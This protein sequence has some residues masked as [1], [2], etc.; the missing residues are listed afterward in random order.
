MSTIKDPAKASRRVDTRRLQ[1]QIS[2]L[3]KRAQGDLDRLRELCRLSQQAES[4]E[5]LAEAGLGRKSMK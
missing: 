1:A 2:A 5:I 4:R 3:T